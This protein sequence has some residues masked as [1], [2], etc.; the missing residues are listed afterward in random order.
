VTDRHLARPQ[1]LAER[2]EARDEVGRIDARRHPAEA[3]NL[4]KLAAC[5]LLEVL[6]RV[7]GQGPRDH[8]VRDVL[9]VERQVEPAHRE[10]QTVPVAAERHHPI[11]AVR[12]DVRAEIGQHLVRD[13]DDQRRVV[14]KGG[15][16][17]VVQGLE[18]AV[19]GE[20]ELPADLAR[21]RDAMPMGEF[22]RF[23]RHASSTSHPA[24]VRRELSTG[25]RRRPGGRR[26]RPVRE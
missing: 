21:R 7:L 16:V 23:S 3:V 20:P 5:V 14:G 25:C 13:L 1:V 2:P 22:R 8:H 18:V 19:V 6:Q 12:A 10:R 4:G 17:G 26:L 9:A 11:G 24:T 15:P